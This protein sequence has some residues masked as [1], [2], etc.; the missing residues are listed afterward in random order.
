MRP[1]QTETVAALRAQIAALER[2]GGSARPPGRCLPFGVP[3]LDACLPG[4]GLALGAMH[5]LF[6][7]GSAVEHGAAPALFA[8]SVLA[9]RAGPV[10]WI[11]ARGDL[12][13]PAL[14]RA[15]LD[16]ARMILVRA[17]H[18]ALRAMEE[19]LRHPGL[20]GVVCEHEG[21]L[22]L[23]A[24]R[25]LQLAAEAA[26]V[27][28]F[29]LRRSQHFDDPALT[30]P[31]AAATRCGSPACPRRRRCRMPRTCPAS[32]ARFGG[33]SCCAAGAPRRPA[34]LWSVRTRRVVSLFLPAW[35]TDRLRRHG[36]AAL[37]V[38]Q[39]LVTRAHDGQRMAVAAV[40]AAARMLGL[41]PAMLLAHA[42][43]L[44]P[45]LAVADADPEG[46][47]LDPATGGLAWFP[48]RLLL[49]RVADP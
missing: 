34:S 16:P 24:S 12:Y 13:P 42:M 20:A 29:V 23:T 22:G 7:G 1:V 18:G 21:R 2:G 6:A 43:A 46:D 8:A 40:D 14:A 39:P 49:R 41:H 38:A 33:W 5:E 26:G 35:P 47:G 44:A 19:S 36:H 25:R 45:G 10:L 11:A 32:A 27:L 28:G 3:E 9:R 48:A 37:P 31:S 4:Q 17:R 15:G 30:A